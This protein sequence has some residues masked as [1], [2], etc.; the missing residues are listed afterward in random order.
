MNVVNL[1]N[2]LEAQMFKCVS[3]SDRYDHSRPIKPALTNECESVQAHFEC[4]YN[5][6]Y[7]IFLSDS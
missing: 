1:K 4:T 6:E 2:R 7:E 3:N 5:I